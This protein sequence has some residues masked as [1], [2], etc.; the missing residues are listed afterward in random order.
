MKRA[1]PPAEEEKATVPV[2]VVT[3]DTRDARDARNVLQKI[4]ETNGWKVPRCQ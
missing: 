3:I 4:I 1:T 2:R